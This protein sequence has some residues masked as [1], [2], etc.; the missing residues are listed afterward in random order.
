MH[1]RVTSSR[2]RACVLPLALLTAGLFVGLPGFMSVSHA[3]S[4]LPR[5]EQP[6]D[7]HVY[8]IS[9]QEGESVASPVIVRFGLGGMGV[10]PA[11]VEKG[12]TGHHHLI[13]DAELPPA[14]L[15]VPNN[16]QYRHFGNGQTEVTLDL[17]PGKHTLQ[18]LLADH[19]HIPHDPPVVSARISITVKE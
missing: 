6:A 5:S 2:I 10:A 8:F 4:G 17:A 12:G 15:P 3:E 13:V 9:P 19:L 1:Q 16:E 11:G 7:A 18:L 14:D